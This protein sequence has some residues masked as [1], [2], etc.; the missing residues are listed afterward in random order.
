MA[1][2]NGRFG[3]GKIWYAYCCSRSRYAKIKIGDPPQEIEMDLNMLASD[4]YVL[5]TTSRKGSR[6]DDYFSQTHSSTLS[7]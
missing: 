5:T 4:F 1:F 3:I 7:R 6:Y 2:G